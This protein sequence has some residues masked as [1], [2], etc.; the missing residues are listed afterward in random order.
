MHRDHDDTP[1]LLEQWARWAWTGH[2][3][4]LKYPLMTPFRRLNKTTSAPGP[5]ISDLCAQEIDHAVARVCSA[6]REVGAALMYT[7]LLR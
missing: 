3:L 1:W 6:N 4:Q 2:G 7:H 5:M